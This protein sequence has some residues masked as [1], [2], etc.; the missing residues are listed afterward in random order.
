MEMLSGAQM[1]V[2][3]LEDEGVDMIFGY[4]GGAVIDIYD[5]LYSAKKLKHVLV[6]HEQAAVHAADGY[7]RSTGKVGVA[8]ATSG[9]GATNCITGIATAYMDSVPLV[10]ITGQVGNKLIGSDAFQEV[11]TV[12][13]TRPIVKHSFLCRKAEDLPLIIKKAFYLAATGRPGPVV[14]DIPK[15]VQNPKVKFE[16]EY[17]KDISMRSYNP[18]RMGHKGQIK[19]AVKMLAEAKHPVVYVGGGVV[20]ANASNDVRKLVDCF[21]LPVVSSLMGL[22]SVSAYDRHFLGMLGMH[23]TYEANMTMHNSDLVLA[24]GTRFSDRSTNNVDKFCPNAKIIHIDI[25]PASISKTVRVDIPIVGAIDAVI[26]QMM[27][28][29]EELG[30]STSDRNLGEWWT[31]ILNWKQ[32]NCLAF[33]KDENFIKPQEVIE[34]VNKINGNDAIVVSDVGQHQ[35]F[36]ALYYKFDQPRQWLNSG[37]LGTMGYGLPAAV[38]AQMANPDKTVVCFTSD[39]S[40]QMNIQEL[41]TCTHYS[42]PLKIVIINNNALGMVKQWQRLFYE[43]RLS[44]TCSPEYIA[45]I[46]N[47]SKLAE[48]YGHVG[49]RIEKP[50]ELEESMK[51]AFAMK[52]KL[53]VIE[54]LTD[55]TELVYPMTI[56]GGAMCDMRLSSTETTL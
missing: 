3:A 48:S 50:S 24:I 38:G 21:D 12:G 23:G 46:P 20:L 39:G 15:D 35:M 13:I 5:A 31:Q 56:G 16:Y 22:G 11:D 9:P 14:I 6:R 25:D 28:A 47:F 32:K 34:T 7:A 19:R 54:V 18:T 4:P 41:A 42:V 2:R 45:S 53:V 30:I 40:V 49:I 10:M 8:L 27:E 52:D 29:I 33:T 37:G 55:P 43:G 44:E 36:T 1:V 26:P 51:K 17:P